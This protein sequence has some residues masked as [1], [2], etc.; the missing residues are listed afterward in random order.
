MQAVLNFLNLINDNWTL[1]ITIIGVSIAIY[2]KAKKYFNLSK[3]EKVNIALS[4]LDEILL[5][6]VA[7]AEKEYKGKT[8]EIK[9]AKVIDEIYTKY[10]I[11]KEY[12]NKEELKT[13]IDMMVEDNLK[14]LKD[15]IINNDIN[16]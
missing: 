10:P 4:Q 13:K 5:E 2:E 8:G 7:R 1:I 6:L 3:Q 11:L 15:I 12:Y 16:L 9:K 14:K